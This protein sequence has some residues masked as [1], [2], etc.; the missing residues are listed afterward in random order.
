MARVIPKDELKSCGTGWLEF[1]DED[2]TNRYTLYLRGHR[3]AG[4]R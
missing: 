2:V 4:I 3:T 1:W